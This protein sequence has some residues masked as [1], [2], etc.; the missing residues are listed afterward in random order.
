MSSNTDHEL[1][2]VASTSALRY[3]ANLN[4]KHSS[5]SLSMLDDIPQG[6]GNQEVAEKS[7]KVTRYE[8]RVLSLP[9]NRRPPMPMKLPT[10]WCSQDAPTTVVRVGIS[11]GSITHLCPKPRARVESVD[12]LSGRDPLSTSSHSSQSTRPTTPN[13]LSLEDIKPITGLTHEMPKQLRRSKSHQL[14][15]FCKS[16]FHQ[17]SQHAYAL[18]LRAYPEYKLTRSVDALRQREYKRLRRSDQ[19]YVDYMGASL[20]PETLI[21]SNSA[22][23][24]QAILGN[25][26]SISASSHQSSVCAEEA[27]SAVLAFF[28]APATEY[29]V[30]FTP[31]ATG[32]MRLVGEAFPFVQGSSYVLGVDSHNSVNG[33]RQ[34]ALDKG[35]E[36]VY[37][38]A[39]SRG[40]MDESE[41]KRILKAHGPKS[42]TP[43]PPCLFAL[44]G[45]SNV[46]NSKVPL[47]LLTYASVLGYHT[48]LDAA[49]LAP[50]SKI[51]LRSTP[52]DAM[53]VSCYKMFG[54]PTGVGCLIAK[55]S[56]LRELKRPW[57][58]GGTVGVVQVPGVGY[59][60][61]Q[62]IHEQFEEGTINFA[63]LAAV[64][65]G[66]NML[67]RYIDLLPLRLSALTHYLVNSLTATRHDT[68]G[69]PVARIVS[70]KP[71]RRPTR[72][73]EQSETGAM[74][75]LIFLEPSGEMMPN[76]FVEY[77]STKYKISLRTGCMC[78]PG[79]VASMLG[80][81]A[82]MDKFYPGITYSDFES[83]V[84][85]ELGAVRFSLGLVSDFHDV[86]R[87]LRFV[88]EV[89]ACD[90]ERKKIWMEWEPIQHHHN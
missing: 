76:S 73:G 48:L 54:F 77:A 26:H 29:T 23:L 72:V 1:M 58:S 8:T 70:R 33:I 86:H 90:A 69:T 4:R 22:F 55:K 16:L 42:L 65:K 13:E 41:A 38:P 82:E 81:Q 60:P 27:R 85:K 28:D 36:A 78:N 87:V 59:T 62:E 32:G 20:Y 5:S 88:R 37:I 80:F 47:S 75:A 67:S 52:A 44:T 25:T 64:T 11:G 46:S 79:G 21:D 61:T 3:P 45:L 53:A 50:S 49:A 40:G 66:L 43:D 84:G 56:F 68:T 74:V 83:I 17:D 15:G 51:S 34:Y 71:G 10:C 18:F 9:S 30:I 7:G 6:L 63:S 14:L 2:D 19:V 57:F 89:I 24:R 31:N 12:T 35:A 39:T